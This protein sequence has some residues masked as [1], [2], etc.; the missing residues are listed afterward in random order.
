MAMY[1]NIERTDMVLIYGE[2]RGNAEEA[3][4]IYMERFPQ[5]LAPAA[6]TFKKTFSI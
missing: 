4:R 3:R 1:T 5:R 6:G 2:A